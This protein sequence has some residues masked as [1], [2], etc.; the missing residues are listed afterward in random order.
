[1]S[2]R[3]GFRS[4]TGKLL[5]A[6]FL[7]FLLLAALQFVICREHS[8]SQYKFVR[9]S[10]LAQAK[11]A[12]AG[13]ESVLDNSVDCLKLTLSMLEKNEKPEHIEQKLQLL[14]NGNQNFIAAGLMDEKGQLICRYPALSPGE[15]L[16]TL[17][18][19]I[20]RSIPSVSSTSRLSDQSVFTIT[21][22]VPTAD[23][24]LNILYAV[25]STD[26]V[27]HALHDFLGE[28]RCVAV[29][30]RDGDIVSQTGGSIDQKLI[31]AALFGP[32]L[33]KGQFLQFDEPDIRGCGTIS[34]RTGWRIAVLEQPEAGGVATAGFDTSLW[35]ILTAALALLIFFTIGNRIA[36]PIRKLSRAAE[37][38]AVGDLRRRVVVNT[39]D[40][41]QSLAINF[42]KMADSLETQQRVL[43]LTTSIQQSLID[44]AKTVSASLDVNRVASSIEDVLKQQ[45][46]AEHV[47]I[48]KVNDESGGIDPI[49]VPRVEGDAFYKAMH[50]LAQH[51]L[52]SPGGDIPVPGAVAYSCR[53]AG[54]L[55]AVTVPLVVGSRPVG[56][57]ITT[58]PDEDC[59]KM[60]L[61]DRISFLGSFA[62]CA[63]IAVH[64][65]C[66]HS[67]TE[68]LIGML[69]SLRRVDES[70]SA[71]LDLRQVLCA[72]V[73][74][75]EEV[76]Q[77][78][79]CA[80]LLADGSGRLSVAEANNLSRKL[81]KKLE[82][83]LQDLAKC[84]VFIENCPDIHNQS[85]DEVSANESVIN[86]IHAPLMAGENV[87]G[88]IVVWKELAAKAERKE[89][90][91]LSAIA[92]HAAVVIA[93]AKMFSREYR[94]AETLQNTLVGVIPDRLGGLMLGNKY[95]SALDEARIG[96]DLFDAITLPNGKIA[97]LIADVSG[98]GIQ[99]AMHTAMVRYMARAFI[100]QWPESPAAALNML[101]RAI[102]SY[103][104]SVAIVTVFCAIIDPATGLISYANAGHPPPII[105]AQSGKQQTM[106]YRTGIPVGYAEDS[107]YEERKAM[108][109]PGDLLLL[110]T[111][112]IIE[113]RREGKVLSTE[114]LQEILFRHADL[115]P[116]E[117]VEMVCEEARNFAEGDLRDDIA[118]IATALEPRPV[119]SKQ[120]REIDYRY[121][122]Y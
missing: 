112:G 74:T 105:L 103:F 26:A 66:T 79:A 94:I 6:F 22:P 109:A 83:E 38:V 42:N 1:M 89:I 28:S 43:R 14:V 70:I 21:I 65:A 120:Q 12:Q 47:V 55:P 77:A 17:P 51:A 78:K 91:L 98:K 113:A 29:M 60:Q 118:I 73:R 10:M 49:L 4:I 50:G 86:R 30:D 41:L 116:R 96:G 31:Y 90:G 100:F 67:R 15:K 37:A 40:E 20:L 64:N 45:F 44:V 84:S 76:M 82:M 5:A 81:Q 52:D 9:E 56:V 101:N 104:G 2:V 27:T 61:E 19:A 102:V 54:E 85:S 119:A 87:V 71:S 3:L 114:G 33:A 53:E 58:F 68:E 8:R 25:V 115:D 7:V 97:L 111:D 117:M 122:H 106:L 80:I 36:S 57:L 62:S 107:R 110:Y 72:L 11:A 88:A 16:V 92:S 63:A 46:G 59:S 39:N 99:A 69:D 13:V 32:E 18:P 48:Y 95:I 93:N 108:L 35:W 24:H 75:T 23:S 34:E 121:T